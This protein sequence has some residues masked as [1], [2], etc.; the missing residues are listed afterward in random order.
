M[1]SLRNSRPNSNG[2][3]LVLVFEDKSV[4]KVQKK[5]GILQPPLATLLRAATKEAASKAKVHY[6]N[7]AILL[8]PETECS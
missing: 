4:S 6:L 5:R 8:L 2:G 1:R 7:R 3:A